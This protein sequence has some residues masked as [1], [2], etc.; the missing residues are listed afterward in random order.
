M[1]PP[2]DIGNAPGACDVTHLG[3]LPCSELNVRT[4]RFFADMPE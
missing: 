4:A 2:D 3:V 1:G